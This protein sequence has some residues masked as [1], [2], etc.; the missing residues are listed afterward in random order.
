MGLILIILPRA[1]FEIEKSFHFYNSLRTDL[2]NI[3]LNEL[4]DY[5]ELV[6]R[7]PQLFR[8]NR[9]EFREAVLKRFP[10][11]II[12]EQFEGYLYVYSIFNTCRNPLTKLE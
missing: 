10:F 4:D 3:F 6:L 7:N 5:F 11:L 2:G 8:K 9:L 12:Y 1:E